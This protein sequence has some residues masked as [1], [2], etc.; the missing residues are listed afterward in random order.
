MALPLLLTQRDLEER[1]DNDNKHHCRTRVASA[2]RAELGDLHDETV[3][4]KVLAGAEGQL[5][6][7]KSS[8]SEVKFPVPV[9]LIRTK[10]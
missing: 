7:C 4:W 1:G 2:A 3:T 6:V 10:H 8:S 9:R 5:K